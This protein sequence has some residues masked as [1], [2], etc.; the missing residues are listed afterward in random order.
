M[1]FQDNGESIAQ[2]HA[3][4]QRNGNLNV[5]EAV[6]WGFATAW[7]NPRVWLL[8]TILMFLAVFAT[9]LLAGAAIWGIESLLGREL[10]FE[11]PREMEL[12]DGFG[13]GISLLPLLITPFLYAGALA[14]VSRA[15]IGYRDFFHRTHYWKVILVS[16]VG[17][18]FWA[19]VEYLFSAALP[20]D[21]GTVGDTSLWYNLGVIFGGLIQVVLVILTQLLTLAWTWYVADGYGIGE[22]VQQGSAAVWRNFFRLTVLFFVGTLVMILGIVFTFGLGALLLIPASLLMTAHLCRQANGGALPEANRA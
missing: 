1:S 12:P 10:T 13:P 16:V 15:K 8:G 14:Q 20:A 5:L 11:W 6:N 17:S 4:T 7:R 21:Q 2:M 9:L 19:A 3:Q 22:A 18:V